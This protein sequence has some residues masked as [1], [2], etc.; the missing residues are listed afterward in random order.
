MKIRTADIV[1]V[2]YPQ[3]SC[4]VELHPL[5]SQPDARLIPVVDMCCMART[6]MLKVLAFALLSRSLG[7]C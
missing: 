7:S 6:G 5:W 1:L 4:L 2:Q 3:P